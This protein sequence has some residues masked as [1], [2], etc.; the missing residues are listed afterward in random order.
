MAS[1]TL[2]RHVCCNAREPS[3]LAGLLYDENDDLVDLDAREQEN[4]KRDRYY[5]ENIGMRAL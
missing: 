5:A 4:G 2:I 3:R 1:N